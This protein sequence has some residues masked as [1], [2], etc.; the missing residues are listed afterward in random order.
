MAKKAGKKRNNRDQWNSEIYQAMQDEEKKTR[1]QSYTDDGL[2][3]RPITTVFLTFLVI[4]MFIIIGGVIAFFLWNNRINSTDSIG[5][6]FYSSTATS[7]SSAVSESQSSTP[8]SEVAASSS[9]S[10]SS[11]SP[12]ST[13]TIQAGDFP[14][15]I[16]GKTGVS[17]SQIAGLNNL[18]EDGYDKSTGAAITPGLVL[19]LK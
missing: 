16:A 11:D 3:K 4:V 1:K 12:E 7:K 14:S 6:S 18:T 10:S 17:W 5:T 9:S 2:A 8:S 19:K 15:T 13:Y